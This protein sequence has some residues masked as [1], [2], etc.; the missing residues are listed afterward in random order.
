MIDKEYYNFFYILIESKIKNKRV[1]TMQQK[2]RKVSTK[3]D[4][5]CYTSKMNNHSWM[6]KK[7]KLILFIH[8]GVKNWNIYKS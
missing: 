1:E 5:T 4:E 7:N 2:L 8:L 3:Q 6:N